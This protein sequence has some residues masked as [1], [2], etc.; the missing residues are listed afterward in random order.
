MILQISEAL[1]IVKTDIVSATG[2]MLL[3]MA[4]MCYVIFRQDKKIEGKDEII[5]DFAEKYYTMSGQ[6]RDVIEKNN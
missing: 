4:G 1:D 3:M 2:L 6:L 5:K